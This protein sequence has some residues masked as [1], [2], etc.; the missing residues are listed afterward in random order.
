[1]LFTFDLNTTYYIAI[2]VHK[3]I[4]TICII[5]MPKTNK[6]KNYVASVRLRSNRTSTPTSYM[7]K[8]LCPFCPL[9]KGPLFQ[10]TSYV[11]NIIMLKMLIGDI[12][13]IIIILFY[14]TVQHNRFI[15]IAS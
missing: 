6:N 7:D 2:A 15:I 8:Y 14:I 9:L 1:M 5:I 12:I 13:I 3:L 10:L 4:I 11:S